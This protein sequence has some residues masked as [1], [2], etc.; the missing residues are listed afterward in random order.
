MSKLLENIKSLSLEKRKAMFTCLFLI[1]NA[2][3]DTSEEEKQ[4]L[5][6][7]GMHILTI[8][9]S[10]LKNG[11]LNPNDLK[12]VLDEMSGEELFGLGLLMG[13][14]A[15]SDGKLDKREINTIKSIL[16]IAKLK[17]D[18]IDIVVSAIEVK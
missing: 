3:D 14:V 15:K 8:P 12:R 17:P 7:Q 16:R 2:D 6:F 4:E 11:G 10:E 18:L 9:I 5:V 13:S 1:A